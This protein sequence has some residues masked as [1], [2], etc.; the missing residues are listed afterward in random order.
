MNEMLHREYAYD[1]RRGI[2]YT[3]LG[4]VVYLISHK[5]G[6]LMFFP[7]LCF[8]NNNL[9]IISYIWFDFFRSQV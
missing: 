5:Y 9:V 6:S 7:H 2:L 3:F 8:I 1:K 4:F